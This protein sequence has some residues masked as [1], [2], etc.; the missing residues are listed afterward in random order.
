MHVV[1]VVENHPEFIWATFEHHASTPDYYGSTS[2]FKKITT[3]YDANKVLSDSDNFI[4]YRK[5]TTAGDANLSYPQG[6][7]TTN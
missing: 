1:G 6:E 2:A 5:N 7:T 3:A 4:F